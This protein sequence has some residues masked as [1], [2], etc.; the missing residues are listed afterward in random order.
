MKVFDTV[1]IAFPVSSTLRVLFVSVL[2]DPAVAMIS[3]APQSAPGAE[4]LIA[5]CPPV[6]HG[7]T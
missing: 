5:T 7:K 4:L 6:E 3:V 1:V 2:V